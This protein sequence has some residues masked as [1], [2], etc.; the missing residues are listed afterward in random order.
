M[1]PGDTIPI[2]IRKGKVKIDYAYVYKSAPN[3]L[4]IVI[5]MASKYAK[6]AGQSYECDGDHYGIPGVYLTTDED[7]LYIDKRYKYDTEVQFPTLDG[8][9]IWS[10]DA[11]KYSCYITLYRNK[12]LRKT[13]KRG[14]IKK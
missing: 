6:L 5:E 13:K 14:R 10:A 12:P 1:K 2:T 3:I 7:T 11:S 8:W 4:L 9:S